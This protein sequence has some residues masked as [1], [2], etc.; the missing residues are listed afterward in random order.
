[1]ILD[2]CHE[3][4]I[5]ISLMGPV[6]KVSCL[7]GRTSNLEID[8]EDL[9]DIT[10]IHRDGGQSNIHLNYLER[11]YEWTT[12]ITGEKGSIIWDYGRGYVELLLPNHDPKRWDN[13]IGFERD[14]LFR[15]Q[16]KRWLSVLNQKTR[17]TV[18]LEEGIEV[19]RISILAKQSSEEKRSIVL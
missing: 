13:P 11:N 15:A 12:R 1:M 17:E 18:S 8:T 4:D 10:L 14:S 7:C 2:L 9:A 5:A 3:I 6:E 16:F 19:T